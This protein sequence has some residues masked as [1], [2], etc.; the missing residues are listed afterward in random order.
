MKQEHP[1]NR[2]IEILPVFQSREE[3]RSY[4]NKISK[5]YDL[6]ADHS[7][8]PVRQEGRT[9]LNVQ[10]GET[11]LEIGCGTGASLVELARATG[12]NG[13]VLGIDLPEG[14]R[15][16]A[17]ERRE[18]AGLS[19][20]VHPTPGDAAHLPYADASLEAVLISFTLELFDTPENAV[21][22]AES[23]RVLK[24][25]G[26]LG[27]VGLSQTRPEGGMI[28]VYEGTHRHFPNL[29]D[30]RPIAGKRSM[31]HRRL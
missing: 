17:R 9:F 22:R 8:A 6:L 30:C 16:V 23:K 18:K 14:M 19:G 21:V 15:E 10:P 25:G 1:K 31:D 28:K 4:S 11:V 12:E 20:R 29:L 26:R 27:V 7:E 5:V 2:R 3:T 24:P 13:P